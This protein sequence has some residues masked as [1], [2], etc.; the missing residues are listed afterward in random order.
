MRR[1]LSL[2]WKKQS[3]IYCFIP[4]IRWCINSLRSKYSEHC[5]L[6]QIYSLSMLEDNVYG[7]SEMTQSLPRVFRS[8]AVRTGANPASWLIWELLT[9]SNGPSLKTEQRGTR[10]VSTQ[11]LIL[12]PISSR[13]ILILSSH[14]RLG[15]PKGLFPAGVPVKILKALIPSSILATC[16]AHLNIQDLITPK[17]Y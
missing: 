8:P 15:L 10:P 1:F 6:D 12:I 4:S 17:L 14:L 5:V 7:R 11:F 9:C 13:F 2:Q 3:F 16:P